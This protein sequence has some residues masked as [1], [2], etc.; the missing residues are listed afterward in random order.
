MPSSAVPAAAGG[1]R[2]F[3]VR[4][5]VRVVALVVV[6]VFALASRT[7]DSAS[8]F[9]VWSGPGIVDAVGFT[10]AETILSTLVTVALGLAPAWAL[11]HHPLPGHRFAH[12][13]TPV[14]F[15]RPTACT[16]QPSHHA[17]QPTP[18]RPPIGSHLSAIQKVTII[19]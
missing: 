15:L 18:T 8:L 1:V 10:V 2:L 13:A 6:P 17:Q 16:L 11:S 7:I 9:G 4:G 19:F 5:L 14:P 3:A 12:A